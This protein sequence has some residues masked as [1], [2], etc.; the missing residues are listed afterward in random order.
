VDRVS[1]SSAGT[2]QHG[3]DGVSLPAVSRDGRWVAF[4]S[5]AS[6]L[7][8]GDTNGS[9]DVFVRLVMFASRA[10]NLAP[11]VGSDVYVH[12]RV[13][14]RTEVVSLSADGKPLNGNAAAGGSMTPD[15]R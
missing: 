6:D 14:H 10:T 1:V 5:H 4:V 8:P 15:G 13:A 11:G 9:N 3:I 12:D 2:E 7:V